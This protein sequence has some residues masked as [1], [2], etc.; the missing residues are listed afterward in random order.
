MAERFQNFIS[1]RHWSLSI[2]ITHSHRATNAGVGVRRLSSTHSSLWLH[3]RGNSPRYPWRGYLAS[4]SGKQPTVHPE[5]VLC[6]TLGETAGGTLGEGT[7]LHTRGNSRRYPW[8]GYLAGSQIRFGHEP[9]TAVIKYLFSHFTNEIL[10]QLLHTYIGVRGG[11]VVLHAG[12][13]RVRF[14]MVSLEFFIDI[15]LPTA[16]WPWGWLS[17]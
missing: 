5:R 8:R 9:S 15:I 7:L 17:L 11:T 1:V 14:P 16:L 4:H 13:S 10:M 3:P 12:R 6:F 2:W